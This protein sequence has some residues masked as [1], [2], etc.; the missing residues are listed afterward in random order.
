MKNGPGFFRENMF[1][2]LEN[3]F[4]FPDNIYIYIWSFAFWFYLV[5]PCARAEI[6]GTRLPGTRLPGTRSW[7]KVA[8]TKLWRPATNTFHGHEQIMKMIAVQ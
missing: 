1:F 2:F 5:L 8:G 7:H 3:K 4:F 6:P